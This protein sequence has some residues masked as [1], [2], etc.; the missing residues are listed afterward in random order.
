MSSYYKKTINP[1]TGKEELALWLDNYYGGHRYGI[2]FKKDGTEI[3]KEED[4]SEFEF[5]KEDELLNN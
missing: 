5:Y 1:K 3:N 4:I 2:G